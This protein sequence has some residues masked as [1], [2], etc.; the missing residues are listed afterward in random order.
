[1][2]R[3]YL[4]IVCLLLSNIVIG[5]GEKLVPL[6]NNPVLKEEWVRIINNP[7][8]LKVSSA[9]NDT[10]LLPFLD[11]FSKPGMFP[12]NDLWIDS[13]AF[14]NTDFPKNPPTIGVATFDGLNKFGNPYNNTNASATGFADALTSKPINTYDDGQGNIYTPTNG[15]F[16]SFFYEQ[17][18]FGDRP[19]TSD[20]LRLEFYNVVTGSWGVAWSVNG[21]T[22]VAADTTFTRVQI[23]ITDPAYFQKG[24][25]FRFR[26]YGSLTGNVDH[27]HID[28]VTLKPP[29]NFSDI[30][31]VAYATPPHSLLMDLSSMPYTHY[32]SLSN[33]SSLMLNSTNYNIHNSYSLSK[34]VGLV[35]E[36]YDPSHN[37]I[38]CN[39]CSIGSNNFQVNAQSTL[40]Y[41][42]PFASFE[43]PVI[44]SQD[45][46][47]FEIVNHIESNTGG[48]LDDNA[49]NDTIHYVQKFINYYAYDDGTAELGYNLNGSGAALAYRFQ[50][51][52]S[53]TLRAI[54][55][56][57]TQIG[58][59][60]SNELF[61]LVV[62]D[63]SGGAPNN[64]VYQK[65]NQTPYYSNTIDGFVTYQTQPVYLTAGIYFFGFIQTNNVTFNLGFDANTLTPSS[66]KYINTTGTWGTSSIP[67]SWM[68]RP[69]FSQAP[70]NVNVIEN[71]FANQFS[72]YPNPASSVLYIDFDKKGH[73]F[74]YEL[75]DPSGRLVMWNMLAEKSIDVSLL[76]NGFY[77]LRVFDNEKKNSFTEK[78]IIYH[79]Y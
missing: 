2:N 14:I 4:V 30:N 52:K 48:P 50:V 23:T 75:R 38:F 62:W 6:K 1:M 65:P 25:Q 21:I 78:V 49:E 41:N 32:K 40:N 36:I 26:N 46:A 29:P 42:F 60:V 8:L 69:V 77:S 43:Y 9:L 24:F 59:S 51:Y 31:D 55:M 79:N 53:D 19:E 35:D 3:F 45:S 57:F 33:P 13:S 44:T 37:L 58:L 20:Q 56:Y 5:Q 16:F 22:A 67:G 73:P 66:D 12:R 74:K 27:W 7:S 76:S 17:K 10:L 54:R 28:Y 11:D 64:I 71:T 47:E 72:V 34:I 70:L 18:G 68:I 63:E 39:G 15:L 61:R